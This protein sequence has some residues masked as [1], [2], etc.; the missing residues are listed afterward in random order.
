MAAI[1]STFYGLVMVAV[2]I[3]IA[4]SIVEDSLFS[5]SAMFLLLVVTQMLIAAILHPRE[6][7]C[8]LYGI[9]YYI[10]VPSMYVLLIMYSLF[11]LNDITWG[12]R[13]VKA[14][15]T[16]AVIIRMANKLI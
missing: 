9:I 13:E 4:I 2:V 7:N 5:P 16:R 6:I 8:L 11:N 3:G 12:T 14:K 1:L 10:S 15:K